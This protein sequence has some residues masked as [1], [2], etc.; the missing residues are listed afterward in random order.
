[1]LVQR[2][3]LLDV[4]ELSQSDGFAGIIAASCGSPQP[5]NHDVALGAYKFKFLEITCNRFQIIIP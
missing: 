3:V 5:K 2:S 4:H 1:M